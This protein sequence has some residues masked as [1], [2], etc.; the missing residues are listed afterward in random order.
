MQASQAVSTGGIRGVRRELL[1]TVVQRLVEG[2]HPE[3]II[4]FG[5]HAWGEPDADS[6]IDLLVI[7]PESDLSPPR[8]ATQARRC[9]RGLP[10]A[11]DILVRTR[12]EVT[13]WEAV[14]ESLL[15]MIVRKGV[16]LYG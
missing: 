9:L 1:E 14:N 12:D 8:R 11:F 4:L 15:S 10:S 13:R 5:S 3:R 6:D 2:L 16:A 7:V